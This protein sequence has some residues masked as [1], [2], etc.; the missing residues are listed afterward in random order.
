MEEIHQ[1]HSMSIQVSKW[2]LVYI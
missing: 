1:H 2:T